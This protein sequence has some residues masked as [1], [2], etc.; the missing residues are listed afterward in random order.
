MQFEETQGFEPF[1][2]ELR[3]RAESCDYNNEKN[4]MILDKIVF[5]MT[6][7]LQEMLLSE[8]ALDLEKAIKTCSSFE[9]ANKHSKEMRETKEQAVQIQ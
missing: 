2:T 8:D 7:K 6:G 9:Q 5:T 3:A 1:L 4:R